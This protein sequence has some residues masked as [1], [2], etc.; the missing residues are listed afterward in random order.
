[1]LN[2]QYEAYDKF[3]KERGNQKE[4]VNLLTMFARYFEITNDAKHFIKSSDLME[5][6]SDHDVNISYR[7]FVKRLKQYCVGKS[8]KS[9]DGN[10]NCLIIL[11]IYS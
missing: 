6:L 7:E 10:T 5:W 3:L 8:D 9:M 2:T 1:M 4:H 11:I